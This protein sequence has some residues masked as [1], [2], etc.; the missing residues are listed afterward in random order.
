MTPTRGVKTQMCDGFLGFLTQG[1]GRVGARLLGLF[2]A[3]MAETAAAAL[4]FGELLNDGEFRLHHGHKH[5]LSDTIARFDGEAVLAAVPERDKNLTM[6]IRI[7]QA[8]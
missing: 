8:D 3:R 1:G 4:A 5:H 7:D 2:P 6:V